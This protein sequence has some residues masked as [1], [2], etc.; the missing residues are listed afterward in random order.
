MYNMFISNLNILY[1]PYIMYIIIL[2][3]LNHHNI[4]GYKLTIIGIY[5]PNEDNGTTIKD[6]FFANLNEEIVKSGNGRQLI[7][8]GDMNGRIGRKLETL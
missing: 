7:L 4:W 1:I 5:A 8:M 3:S 2:P 6:E